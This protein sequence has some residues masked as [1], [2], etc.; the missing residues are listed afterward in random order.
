M[1]LAKHSEKQNTKQVEKKILQKFLEKLFK[2][3]KYKIFWEPV[4][5]EEVPGYFDVI[6]HPM[7]FSTIKKKLKEMKYKT[8]KQFWVCILKDFCNSFLQ[9][10]LELTFKN[11]KKFNPSDTIFH[12]EA[13]RLLKIVEEELSQFSMESLIVD[14]KKVID[15]NNEMNGTT[16]SLQQEFLKIVDKLKKY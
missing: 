4:S 6:K 16:S 13:C 8:V 12:K 7:D 9:D 15:N 5:A 14:G 10:D 3:D 11:A 1:K 2:L